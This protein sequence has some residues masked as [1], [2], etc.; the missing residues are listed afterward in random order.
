MLWEC[1]M[2]VTAVGDNTLYGKIGLELQEEQRDSPLKHR[3]RMLAKD[4]SRLGYIGAFFSCCFFLFDVI[5]K[6]NLI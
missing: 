4:I 6:N 3:L 2:L 5:V 1:K